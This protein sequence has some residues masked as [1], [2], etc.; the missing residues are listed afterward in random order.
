MLA[1]VKRGSNEGVTSVTLKWYFY[2][3]HEV[4][5]AEIRKEYRG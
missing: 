5:D 4:Y 1:T 3:I 2:M